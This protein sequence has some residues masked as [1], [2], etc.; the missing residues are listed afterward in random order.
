[1]DPRVSH[2]GSGRLLHGLALHARERHQLR[3]RVH[4]MALTA[5]AAV[6]L[7]ARRVYVTL[8]D[9]FWTHGR[10]RIN[11]RELSS[12]CSVAIAFETVLAMGDGLPGVLSH[13]ACDSAGTS[14]TSATDMKLRPTDS[15]GL[16][17]MPGLIMKF[18]AGSRWSHNANLLY[19]RVWPCG[20]EC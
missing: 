9:C 6:L 11:D 4:F 19:V 13:V 15:C 8:P 17:E 16:E 12:A 2:I 7:H 1:M 3:A 5:S 10:Q 14:G 20:F 18:S